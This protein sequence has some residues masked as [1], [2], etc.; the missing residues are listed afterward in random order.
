LDYDQVYGPVMGIDTF[1]ILLALSAAWKLHL[2]AAD[3]KTAYLNGELDVEIFKEIPHGIK[4]TTHSPDGKRLA[5]KLQ[6]ALYGLKQ[7][8]CHA[9]MPRD[10]FTSYL[11]LIS[12][13]E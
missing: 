6:K 7:S 4:N 5:L 1:R 8:G 11:A 10:R 9:A 13:L 3:V 2:I 12:D